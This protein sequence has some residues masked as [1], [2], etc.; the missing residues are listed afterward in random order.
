MTAPN[1]LSLSTITGKTAV[2]N[3]TTTSSNVVTN[4]SGSN[5]VL[6]VNSLIVSNIDPANTVYV[7]AGLL[8]SSVL[9]K[10]ASTIPIPCNAAIVILA[11]DSNI[12]LEE[13]DAV[14]ISANA[15]NGLHAVLS[16]EIIG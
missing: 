2:A 14:S 16:Y 10:V 15:N 9:W 6:K 8:R 4:S 11:K 5:Q 12:Y 1:I 7:T 13:G 3:V